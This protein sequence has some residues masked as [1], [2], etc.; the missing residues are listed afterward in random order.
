MWSVLRRAGAEKRPMPI[1]AEDA[2]LLM[3]GAL[4]SA[5]VDTRL[6]TIGMLGCV[7]QQSRDANENAVIGR[8][9]LSSLSDASLEVVT[10]A[11]NAVFDVYGDEQFDAAFA[12]LGFLPALE[13]T[14]AAVKAKLR[15]EQRQLDRD[16]V[17]HVKETQLNLAR[18]IKYKKKHLRA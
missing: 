13:S 9:L 7:G 4:Q 18:F 10:E 16:L 1:A 14:A 8:C 15:A 11:L 17:A 12:Q 3:H 5:S 6:N 2:E